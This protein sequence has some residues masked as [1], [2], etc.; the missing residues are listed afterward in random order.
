MDELNDLL[1]TG[2]N[3]LN[4]VESALNKGDYSNLGNSIRGQVQDAV[5]RAKATSGATFQGSASAVRTTH[6]A[7]AKFRSPFFRKKI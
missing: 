3:I 1:K 5:N 2:E 4:T 7:S 6:Y